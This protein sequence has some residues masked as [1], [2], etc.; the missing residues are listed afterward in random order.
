MVSRRSF[1]LAGAAAAL[2]APAWALS[3]APRAAAGER[4]E[5]AQNAGRAHA[6]ASLPI[7]LR[8]TSG[9]DTVHA[10]ISGSDESGWPGFVGADGGFHRLAAPSAVLTPVPDHSIPLGP[11]GS[12]GVRVT[13]NQYV[14][15]GRV[16]FSVGRKLEF[17]VN[18]PVGG[19]VPGMVQPAL[20][21]ADPNWRTNWTFCEFTYNSANLY[22]NI[23]YVDMVS[24]PVAMS[25]TGSAGPQSVPPLP[26]GALGRI[27][28]GLRAQHAADGAP[29]DR[30]VVTDD[31]GKVVRAMAPVHEASGFGDYW[32]P[33]LDAVWRHFGTTP[34][35]VDGQGGIGR[36]TGRVTGGALVLAGLDDN[37]VPFTRPS[38]VDIFGC[39]SGP[40]YNS[41][42]DA[43]GAVAARLAAALNRSSLLVEGGHD[44]PN[45]VPPER[46]YTHPVTNHYA[47][48]VHEHATVGY[49]FPY[50]DVGPTGSTPVDGH[51]QDGAPASWTLELGPGT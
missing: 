7:T 50:D 31:A 27:A 44:Q 33:Y 1:V 4:V 41:G 30:L 3:H 22:A 6:A 8:N 38:A 36:F 19:G 24:L 39:A 32:E 46:Y 35:T 42:G 49:A 16:W 18:P 47:R 34:L 21:P 40:L 29:W 10:Y 45:G 28:D 37:G 23:S 51:L 9:S 12:P 43:R 13:L 25:T 20:T 5:N 2:G 14:I 15:S 26:V 11:S 17:F 48:L